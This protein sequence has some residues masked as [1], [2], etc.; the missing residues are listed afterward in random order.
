VLFLE[1]IEAKWATNHHRTSRRCAYVNE[2]A[3]KTH[4]VIDWQ[5]NSAVRL[6]MQVRITNPYSFESSIKF[7]TSSHDVIIGRVET[8]DDVLFN[9]SKNNCEKC[10]AASVPPTS[11][12]LFF[13]FL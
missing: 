2:R 5:Q 8:V 3:V 7:S 9:N 11:L 1:R 12:L 6:R 4:L 13:V 10:L